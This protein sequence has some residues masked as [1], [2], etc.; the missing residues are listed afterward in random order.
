[1]LKAIIFV[2]IAFCGIGNVYAFEPIPITISHTMNNVVFDGKWTH[3]FEWKASSLITYKYENATE[4]VLRTA[5]QENFVYV[6]LDSITDYHP[7]L[8]DH[9]IICFDT[10]NNKSEMTDSNDYCFET[11]LNAEESFVYQ[12]DNES[13]IGFSKIEK[14]QGFIAKSTISDMNDR[15]TPVPHPSFEFRVPTELIG[16]QSVYGF[17]FSVYDDYARKTYTYPQNADSQNF[18]AMPSKWG[19]IY[20]PDK[21]LPE[22]ELPTLALIVSLTSLVFFSQIKRRPT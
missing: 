21:S 22:F 2:L 1:M 13:D 15:Y 6:F 20:S 16:R 5:H 3:E 4:I 7:N 14:P 17:Y 11:Y 19:E 10:H 9:A 12:G 18:V 8:N